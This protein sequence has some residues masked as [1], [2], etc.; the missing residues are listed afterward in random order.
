M[1]QDSNT[2]SDLALVNKFLE[3]L[4]SVRGRPRVFLMDDPHAYG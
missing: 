2:W 1:P 3:L 4:P